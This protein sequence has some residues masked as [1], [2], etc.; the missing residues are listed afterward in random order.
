MAIHVKAV[1]KK[2][3]AIALF[4]KGSI[5]LGRRIE[6]YKG[7]KVPFGGHWS[8][9][10]G[11]IEHGETSLSAA[12][13]EM[14]EETGIKIEGNPIFIRKYKTY[15]KYDF[16][17]YALSID[18]LPK[19]KINFEHDEYGFFS[20]NNLPQPM[21]AQIKKNIKLSLSKIRCI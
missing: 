11:C 3:A 10:G 21:D 1:S 2:A 18:Y 16:W 9:F 17:A 20:T 4:C 19:V 7:K 13:R 14:K 15:N 8:L 6:F 5:L 12:I